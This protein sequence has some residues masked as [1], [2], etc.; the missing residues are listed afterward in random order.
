[1]EGCERIYYLTSKSGGKVAYM[2]CE[3]ESNC[4]IK[5]LTTNPGMYPLLSNNGEICKEMKNIGTTTKEP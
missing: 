3:N 5:T 2:P 4:I 1:M